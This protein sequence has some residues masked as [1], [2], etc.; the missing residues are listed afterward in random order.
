MPT[1][2]DG[3]TFIKYDPEHLY[4]GLLVSKRDYVLL[5][6]ED[7]QPC[8][9]G[10]TRICR[11]SVPLFDT[12][13]LNC[14]SSLYFQNNEGTPL[15]KRSLLQ[16]YEQPT[17]QRHGITW[18]YQFPTRQQV[19]FRCPQGSGWTTHIRMLHGGG[20]IHGANTC[21]VATD[22]VRTLPELRSQTTRYSQHLE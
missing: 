7:L 11:M 10:N 2:I 1:R 21:A 6:A 16:S 5:K 12:Q 18:V 14:E 13:T 4:F 20:L 17:L 19:T 9:Q 8:T 3:N 22:R 15:C